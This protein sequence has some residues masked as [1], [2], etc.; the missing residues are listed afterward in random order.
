[1]P[2]TPLAKGGGTDDS[3]GR[4]FA[5][6]EA[7]A[8]LAETLAKRDVEVSQPSMKAGLQFALACIPYDQFISI[9]C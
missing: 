7:V 4:G 6:Q 8:A 9:L 3:S 5:S 1:M 2:M